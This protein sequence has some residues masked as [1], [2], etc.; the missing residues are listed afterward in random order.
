MLRNV[1]E[2]SREVRGGVAEQRERESAGARAA[3]G[4]GESD[5]TVGTTRQSVDYSIDYHFRKR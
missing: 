4:H 1:A 2:S 5:G 3:L